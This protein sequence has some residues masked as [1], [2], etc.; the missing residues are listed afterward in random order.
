MN[1]IDHMCLTARCHARPSSARNSFTASTAPWSSRSTW[2]PCRKAHHAL[3]L[4]RQRKQGFAEADRHHAVALAMQHQDWRGDA[5]DAQVRATR[6]L[7]QPAHRHE[8]IGGGA[9]VGGGGERR[10]ENERRPPHARR[11]A[12]WRPRC[13]ATRPTARCAWA[14]SARRLSRRRRWRRG[15]GPARSACRSSRHSRDSKARC[16]PVPSAISHWKRPTRKSS[17]PALPWK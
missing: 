11:R 13:R 17:A 16:S 5:D 14:H 10:I 15:S 6:V 8:R 7:D 3:G 4:A 12:R 2:P 1:S 9:D